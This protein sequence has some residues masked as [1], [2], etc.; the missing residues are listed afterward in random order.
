MTTTLTALMAA[1]HLAF[2]VLSGATAQAAAWTWTLYEGEGPVVLANEVPDTPQL[3]ATLECTPGSGVARV[4][5]Y[6]GP[7]AAGIATVTSQGGSAQAQTEAQ[8]GRGG[9]LSLALR[10]DH[11]VFGQFVA[12][13]D[14]TIAVGDQHQ[15]VEIEAAHLAKLR[16]FADL[17]SG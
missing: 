16:R 14:L 2:A 9:K 8:T 6:G 5:V 15:D 12:S 3:K 4:S 11:P 17:C 1:T 7:L 13:G 10:T